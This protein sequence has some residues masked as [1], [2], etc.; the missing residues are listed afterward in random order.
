MNAP[1][2]EHN[3]ELELGHFPDLAT[4]KPD[5]LRELA[6]CAQ[7][8]ELA[9]DVP[10]ITEGQH[11]KGLYLVKSGKLLVSKRHSNQVHEVGTISAGDIFGETAIALNTL[12]NAEVRTVN[13]CVLVKIPVEPVRKLISENEAFRAALLH[14]AEQRSAANA[15]AINPVLSRL[16]TPIRDVL[17]SNAEYMRL[18]PGET[19]FVQGDTDI[20]AMYLIIEGKAETSCQS[21]RQ[22]KKTLIL[23]RPGPGDLLGDA[24]SVSEGKRAV[25]VTAV[26][27]LHLMLIDIHA[28]AIW[29]RR[30]PDLK[31]ASETDFK[32]K[33]ERL[34]TIRDQSKDNHG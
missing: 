11:P 7:N 28:P 8:L 10:V 15:L 27:E 2:G 12:A 31:Q 26:T 3:I 4:L 29:G 21:P 6:A 22:Q 14:L 19:L 24:A 5:S 32:R 34:K 1:T 17:L 16:P 20:D 30:F 13:P 23:E 33:W 18:A 25:T 9:A